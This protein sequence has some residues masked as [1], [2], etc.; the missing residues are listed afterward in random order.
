MIQINQHEIKINSNLS[1]YFYVHYF[2][3]IHLLCDENEKIDIQEFV[4]TCEI[5]IRNMTFMFTKREFIL[6]FNALRFIYEKSIQ[7]IYMREYEIGISNNY[8]LF[9]REKNNT[10]FLCDLITK[11]KPSNHCF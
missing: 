9:M 8:T 4:E 5:R 2:G 11:K 7:W 1:I 3:D 6:F 10:I